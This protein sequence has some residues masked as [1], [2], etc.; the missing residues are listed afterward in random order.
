MT[1]LKI[2]I[3]KGVY[4]KLFKLVLTYHKGNHNFGF[5]YLDNKKSFGYVFYKFHNKFKWRKR[6]YS[7][8]AM[9]NNIDEYPMG[10]W[11]ITN[12]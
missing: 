12:D 5:F 7:H 2:T 8:E 1:I 4:L 11:L 6:K 9:Q 3:N 10:N